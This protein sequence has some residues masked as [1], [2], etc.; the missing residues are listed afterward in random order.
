MLRVDALAYR[1]L[2]KPMRQA[3]SRARSTGPIRIR[4][5][6]ESDLHAIDSLYGELKPDEYAGHA[7]TP[8]KMRAGFRRIARSRDHHLIVAEF[9][10]KVV[11]TVHVLIFRHLGH[12]TRPSAIIENVI[13]TEAMRSH[14]IGEK[15]LEAAR[16]I[17]V[18]ER[19]YK[20]ALTSRLYRK[21]AHR[22]YER[23]G[24]KH[25]HKGF[26]LSLE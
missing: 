11:G 16:L 13:V 14:G 25:L 4:R 1:I 19:C 18:R 8:A 17:A 24:W 3:N 22:F 2:I 9:D 10:G 20:L 23:L 21:A 15:M 7:P 12:G 6:R 5:A 26:A